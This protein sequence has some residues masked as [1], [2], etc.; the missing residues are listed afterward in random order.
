MILEYASKSFNAIP[1]LFICMRQLRITEYVQ[2]QQHLI[3]RALQ[4]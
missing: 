2:N 3:P 4:Q 1:G